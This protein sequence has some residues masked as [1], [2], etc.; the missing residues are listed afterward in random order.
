MFSVLDA[1]WYV[2]TAV[3]YAAGAVTLVALYHFVP[4]VYKSFASP[5]RN[6]RGPPPDSLFYGNFK[7]I[8]TA[9]NSVL[10]EE[11]EEKYGS[12]IAYRG[13]FGVR[14]PP[15]VLFAFVDVYVYRRCGCG[16]RILGAGGGV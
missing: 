6:L 13:L 11:W 8:A 5:L 9:E 2:G 3:L 12:T 16:R 10:Q 1:V 4:I 7:A 14:V 15:D